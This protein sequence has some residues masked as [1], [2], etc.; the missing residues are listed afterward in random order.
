M[1]LN[2]NTRG[3][4]IN[5]MVKCQCC[6]I[7]FVPKCIQLIAKHKSSAPPPPEYLKCKVNRVIAKLKAA[8][9]HANGQSGL[10]PFG[11]CSFHKPLTVILTRY[12]F[13][14]AQTPPG[15]CPSPTNIR[16]LH[17]K[18]FYIHSRGL[19]RFVGTVQL[20]VK[21]HPSTSGCLCIGWNFSSERAHKEDLNDVLKYITNE[22]SNT[23]N[24]TLS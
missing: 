21:S 1:H 9:L 24:E 4:L 23:Q 6:C 11:F 2:P 13:T 18:N 17:D 15:N 19:A 8:S 14:T 12:C 22:I 20:Q 10:T 3:R 16:T 7:C 5:I